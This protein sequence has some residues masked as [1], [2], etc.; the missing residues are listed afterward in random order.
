MISVIFLSCLLFSPAFASKGYRINDFIVDVDGLSLKIYNVNAPDHI[1]W[2]TESVRLPFLKAGNALVPQAPIVDGNF[3]MVEDIL[4][5]TTRQ[6]V[7]SVEYVEDQSLVLR[8]QLSGRS[9]GVLDAAKAGYSFTLAPSPLSANHLNFHAS[10]EDGDGQD[11]NRLF[12]SYWADA[13]ETFHGFGESFTDFSL[14]GRRVPVL[15]SEQGVGRGTEPITSF[16]NNGT[17]GTGGHWYSTYAPKPLYLTSSNRSVVFE[18]SEVM[19]VDLT[20][21]GHVEA[22]V[23]ARSLTG[24]VIFAQS[25]KAA[26]S[27]MTLYTGRMLTPP[28]W[29]QKGAVVGLEGGTE[30]VSA[31]VEALKAGGVPVAGVWLQDWVGLR[32]SWDGDRLIYN[33]E[34]NYDWYPGWG[35]MVRGWA[36]EGTRVLTYVN[37]HFS[38]PSEFTNQS[39]HNFYQ[40]GVENGYFVKRADGSPYTLFSLS[41]EFCMVDLTNPAAVA[42]MKNIIR[43]FSVQEAMSSGWMADF[44]EYLPFDAVLYSGEDPASYHNRYP[45]EWAKLTHEALLEEGRADDILYFMRSA[46]LKSPQYNSV[47]WEG[48]QLVTWD[49]NDGLKN[50]ILGALSGGISG[51]AMS[52][53]DIG[54]YTV[55]EYEEPGCTFLRTEELLNRWTEL[56]TFG[57]ALFRT[58]VGSSTSDSNFNVYDSPESIAHFAEFANIYGALKPYRD[59]LI[60]EAIGAG[61]PL[62]RPLAM[63]YA[64]DAA[65]WSKQEEYLFGDDFLVAPCM[66]EGAVT[67][68]VYFPSM[69]G[70]WVHLWS[71]EELVVPVGE[72]GL[73]LAVSAPIGFPPVFYRSGSE[74]GESLRA[75]VVEQGYTKRYTWQL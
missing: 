35:D 13:E 61:L 65:A 57:A 12:L 64:Y 52:H 15:V 31:I 71:G 2:Q 25:M 1:V 38:D 18:N 41:I 5:T 40:E 21:P 58:H 10:L 73:E 26:V 37:P 59:S 66:E 20:V 42:W 22:E 7:T 34:V 16:L 29:S 47:F 68:Q 72:A 75:Y 67:V 70:A 62:I 43:E 27:E 4:F 9:V 11:L 33:W 56:S 69:S 46:W 17:E 3:Q 30:E 8:G 54:G 32:H 53:S 55:T 50:V 63:N 39:R 36:A 28:E 44:G 24:N 6:T 48:D 60:E 49:A 74:Y 19:F 51:H 45:E 14:N 23:W